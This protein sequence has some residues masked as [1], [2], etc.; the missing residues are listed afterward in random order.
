MNSAI[1][2][3]FCCGFTLPTKIQVDHHKI[4]YVIWCVS[5]SS[6]EHSSLIYCREK[7]VGSTI[8]PGP[9][10]AHD[11][12]KVEVLRFLLVLLSRQIYTSPTSVLTAA[13]PYSLMLVQRIPRRHVLTVLCSLLNTAMNSSQP[14]P[15][16]VGLGS[17]RT[18]VMA[19]RHCV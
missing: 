18:M 15:A 3:L 8:D 19:T 1:D 16:S 6:S 2:L 9:T 12:N 11:L 7:G 5:S 13:S 14:S 10:H 4:N 17:V